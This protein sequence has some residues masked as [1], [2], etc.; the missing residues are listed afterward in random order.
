M[1]RE[2]LNELIRGAGVNW[3]A[4]DGVWFQAIEMT[5]DLNDA[6]RCNDSCWVR[7]AAFE[8]WSIKEFLGLSEQAGL[9]GLKKALRFRLYARIHKQSLIA[10]PDGSL[11]FQMNPV[12][13]TGREEAQ[14]ASGLPL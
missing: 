1:P 9:E 10:E 2:K 14:G 13:H 3:S 5:R 4:N 8:A 12:P 6:K 7:F 11:V